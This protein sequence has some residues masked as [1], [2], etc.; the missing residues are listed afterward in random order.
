MNQPRS[1]KRKHT[2]AAICQQRSEH[3][4]DSTAGR[5]GRDC[6]GGIFTAISKTKAYMAQLFVTNAAVSQ[7]ATQKRIWRNCISTAIG[8]ARQCLA[9]PDINSDQKT[10]AES[11]LDDTT[12]STR[13]V[14]QPRSAKKEHIWRNCISLARYSC[15]STT[16]NT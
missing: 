8:K 6:Q 12:V 1:A 13:V 3:Q 10:G 2:G 5:H 14:Y 11:L 16:I 15:I 7:S 9:P 4:S